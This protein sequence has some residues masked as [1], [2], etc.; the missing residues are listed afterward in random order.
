MNVFFRFLKNQF[1]TLKIQISILKKLNSTNLNLQLH[2]INIGG[3]HVVQ[4]RAAHFVS[5]ME[6]EEVAGDVSFAE[7]CRTFHRLD[8]REPLEDFCTDRV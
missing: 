5:A 3:D 4:A 8:S 7:A 2:L 1:Y 6:A